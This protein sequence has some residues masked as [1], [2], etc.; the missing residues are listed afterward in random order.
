MTR[1]SEGC[2]SITRGVNGKPKAVKHKDERSP[3]GTPLHSRITKVEW[4]Q[5]TLRHSHLGKQDILDPGE[6]MVGCCLHHLISLRK[7]GFVTI[8][9]LPMEDQYA[10]VQFVR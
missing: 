6:R 5:Y 8:A 4:G 10:L 9:N 1:C 2:E 3:R 7:S